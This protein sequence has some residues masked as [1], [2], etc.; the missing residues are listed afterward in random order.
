MDT[1]T[2][3]STTQTSHRPV[4]SGDSPTRKNISSEHPSCTKIKWNIRINDLIKKIHTSFKKITSF[5]KKIIKR[6]KFSSASKLS[7]LNNLLGK[8]QKFSDKYTQFTPKKT[9]E[10]TCKNTESTNQTQQLF[11]SIRN[12][13]N[14]TIFNVTEIQP[15]KSGT[16]EKIQNELNA[17]SK[18]VIINT[19]LKLSNKNIAAAYKDFDKKPE[20]NNLIKSAKTIAEKAHALEDKKIT[21][22]KI[23]AGISQN[24]CLK[25]PL[26]SEIDAIFYENMNKS[27][28][29]YDQLFTSDLNHYID[30]TLFDHMNR[31]A[32]HLIYG[33]VQ[34]TITLDS[35]NQLKTHEMNDLS[36]CLLNTLTTT[37]HSYTNQLKNEINLLNDSLNAKKTDTKILIQDFIAIDRLVNKEYASIKDLCLT[38]TP[39]N[40]TVS[41][42]FS[43][44]QIAIIDKQGP[45]AKQYFYSQSLENVFSNSELTETSN[46]DQF[47]ETFFNSLISHPEVKNIMAL[48]DNM[49][50]ADNISVTPFPE[51]NTGTNIFITAKLISRFIEISTGMLLKTHHKD[52]QIHNDFENW[53]KNYQSLSDECVNLIVVDKDFTHETSK[54]IINTAK[55]IYAVI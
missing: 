43:S 50:L 7:I 41:N 22:E 24:T 36:D 14:H 31:L 4:T 25:S 17:L 49:M 38:I 11:H 13:H 40:N 54:A 46:D 19:L 45:D 26:L 8:K 32:R 9:A 39:S 28:N 15:Q 33:K 23:F 44:E 5:D 1:L 51:E 16:E 34:G 37:T 12:C 55:N 48:S 2:V 27:H 52:A 18:T 6:F 42:E 53:Q 3:P 10:S 20:L 21:N 47:L 30:A 29:D 35:I